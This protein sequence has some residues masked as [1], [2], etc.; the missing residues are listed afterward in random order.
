MNYDPFV[1]TVLI[2]VSIFFGTLNLCWYALC[3]V[4]MTY[5]TVLVAFVPVF[6]IALFVGLFVLER[7]ENAPDRA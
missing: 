3:D 5:K 6:N 4:R 2:F 1:L 7:A